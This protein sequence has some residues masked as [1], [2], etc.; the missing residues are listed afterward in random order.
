MVPFVGDVMAALGAVVHFLRTSSDFQGQAWFQTIIL[1]FT[2]Y[3]LWVAGYS[4]G[5]QWTDFSDTEVQK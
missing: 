1:W 5:L 3:G 4:Y 2:G